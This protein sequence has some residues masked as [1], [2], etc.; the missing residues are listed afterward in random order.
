MPSSDRTPSAVEQCS[1]AQGKSL[2]G[3]LKKKNSFQKTSSQGVGGK[4][5]RVSCT[6]RSGFN[7]VCVLGCMLLVA[8]STTT[9]WRIST[10]L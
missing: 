4:G 1:I 5:C 6:T 10:A 8:T 9:S 2:C 7:F 3:D